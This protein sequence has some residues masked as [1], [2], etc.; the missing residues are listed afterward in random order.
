MG[1]LCEPSNFQL[2]NDPVH[3]CMYEM[4]GGGKIVWVKNI[5]F[6]IFFCNFVS[7]QSDL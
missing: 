2:F 5:S 7:Q 3:W 4:K 1:F 6:V